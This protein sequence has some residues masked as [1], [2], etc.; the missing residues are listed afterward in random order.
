MSWLKKEYKAFKTSKTIRL[1]Y[2]KKLAGLV[3][4]ILSNI[5]YFESSLAP[6]TFGLVLIGLGA[7]DNHLR[8]VTTK[9]LDDK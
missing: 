3:S 7:A 5:G 2:A 6:A 1:A 4:L 8:K 9:S